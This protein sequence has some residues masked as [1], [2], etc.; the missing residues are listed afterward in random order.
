[1]S[2]KGA[3]YKRTFLCVI[4]VILSNLW[5]LAN[6]FIQFLCLYTVL[7]AVWLRNLVSV[8]CMK[9]IN[10]LSLACFTGLL[11]TDPPFLARALENNV[12]YLLFKSVIG[13]LCL[14]M[15]GHCGRMCSSLQTLWH[16]FTIRGRFMSAVVQNSLLIFLLP[17]NLFV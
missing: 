15:L 11:E 8:Y 4:T 1:M 7:Y 2:W 5:T 9:W 16:T 3:V 17:L 6:I 10:F 12:G 14:G 13:Q